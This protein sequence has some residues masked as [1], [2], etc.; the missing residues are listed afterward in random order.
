MKPH[1]MVRYKVEN[2]EKWLEVFESVEELRQS[3]GGKTW[4]VFRNQDDLSE[5]V[6][7]IDWA[8]FDEARAYVASDEVR[9]AVVE[10]GALGPPEITYL[11]EV[12]KH[13]PGD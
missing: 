4:R 3:Y 10:A 6:V 13:K 9:A 7:L 11:D 5:V 8:D 2:F 1:V 12:K